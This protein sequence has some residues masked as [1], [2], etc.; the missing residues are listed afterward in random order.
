MPRNLVPAQKI[1]YAINDPSQ[2]GL[3]FSIIYGGTVP[4][5]F[6]RY[7][8]KMLE[9]IREVFVANFGMPRYELAAFSPEDLAYLATTGPVL[10]VQIRGPKELALSSWGKETTLVF[11]RGAALDS[12][13]GEA[14][15]VYLERII[16]NQPR[17]IHKVFRKMKFE[18]SEDEWD[19][20]KRVGK[21]L[22]VVYEIPTK[23]G[24]RNLDRENAEFLLA[25]IKGLASVNQT[26]KTESFTGV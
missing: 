23:S 5:Q 10:S 19:N 24:K 13:H 16:D 12:G 25:V 2:R 26:S 22:D 6:P 14:R 11:L 17:E 18:F 20:I 1:I 21:S 4:P 9:G 3:F 15:K 8:L 7:L